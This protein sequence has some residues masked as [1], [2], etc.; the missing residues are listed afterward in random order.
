MRTR[1][2]F[3]LIEVMIATTLALVLAA[4]AFGVFLNARKA[5]ERAQARLEL[6]QRARTAYDTLAESAATLQHTC[7]MAVVARRSDRASEAALRATPGEVSLLFLRGVLH[8]TDWRTGWGYDGMRRTSADMSWERWRWDRSTRQLRLSRGRRVSVFLNQDEAWRKDN[9]KWTTTE[10][11]GIIAQ[12]RRVFATLAG[13]ASVSDRI[14][15]LWSELDSNRWGAMAD[16]QNVGDATNL[17]QRETVLMDGVDDLVMDVVCGDGQGGGGGLGTRA[18]DEADLCVVYD[19]LYVDGTATAAE[20]AARPRLLRLRY[21]LESRN[22]AL[23]QVFTQSFAIT[24]F[25][26]RN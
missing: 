18:S 5:V 24:P 19:G 3:T 20:V 13:A 25:L 1:T 12:P 6:H 4:V 9:L 7:A 22:G 15:R 21:A 23:R 2:A 26:P 10:N 8:D 17:D 14:T 11:F 16:E